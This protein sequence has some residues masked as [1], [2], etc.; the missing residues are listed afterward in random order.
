MTHRSP[1]P[2]SEGYLT[3]WAWSLSA[4]KLTEA[5]A[6]AIAVVAADAVPDAHISVVDPT[7]WF[8]RPL[9]Q[10]A[11]A[12]LRDAAIAGQAAADESQ[13]GYL[14]GVLGVLDDWL[15]AIGADDHRSDH[16]ATDSR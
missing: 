7:K 8:H 10:S 11:V 6:M 3:H 12:A 4:P 13:R 5:Q 1:Q 2:S 15:G 14:L 16:H 9:S